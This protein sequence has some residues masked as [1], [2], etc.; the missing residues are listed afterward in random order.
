MADEEKKEM[1]KEEVAKQWEEY[2]RNELNTLLDIYLP[3]TTHGN[4]GIKYIT[5]IKEKF[6]THTEYDETKAIGVQLGIVF[7]FEEA[8]DIPKEEKE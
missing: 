3:I 7:A 6:E 1:T 5:P 2:V 8:I 4:V